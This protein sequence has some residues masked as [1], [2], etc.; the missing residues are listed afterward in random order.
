MF[1][2][3]R[4]V[5]PLLHKMRAEYPVPRVPRVY[6]VPRVP[7]VPA[8]DWLCSDCNSRMAAPVGKRPRSYY[9]LLPC[10]V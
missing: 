10:G 1:L 9:D 7:H 8:G 5:R 3:H 4:A 6:H 2:Q